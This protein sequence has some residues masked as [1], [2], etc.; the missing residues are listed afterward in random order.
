M[1]QA[2]VVM[3]MLVVMIMMMMIVAMFVIMVV[4]MIVIVPIAAEEVRLDVEDAVQIERIAAKHFVDRNIGALG[5][6]HLGIRIDAAD[7]RL[8]LAQLVGG[9]QIC[10]VQ[11]DHIGEGDL[12]L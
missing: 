8:N 4:V 6:M 5:A 12:V 11:Q 9:N 3:L 7:A 2:V 1:L 10:L